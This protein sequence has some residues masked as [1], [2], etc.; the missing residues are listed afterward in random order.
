MTV[1]IEE[2][3]TLFPELKLVNNQEWVE[4]ACQIWNEVFERSK[5][6]SISSA[7]FGISSPGITLVEHTRATLNIAMKIMEIIKDL[8]KNPVEINMDVLIIAAILHDVDKLLGLKPGDNGDMCRLSDIG[9]DYQHGFYSAYYAEQAGL[10]P[11]IVT[12]LINHTAFSRVM[13]STIEGMILILAD[14]ADAELV[15]FLFGH[16]STVLQ[17]LGKVVTRKK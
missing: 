4:K 3:K 8:H 17:A 16:T 10:P 15:K 11:S 9:S 5:W 6:D 13:P 14:L 12:I 1:T 7:Q 2:F